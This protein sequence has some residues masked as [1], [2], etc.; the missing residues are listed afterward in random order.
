MGSLYKDDLLKFQK[1][2]NESAELLGI[3]VDY[4]Y[5][6]KRKTKESKVKQEEI[7]VW[8][9]NS[10]KKY[11]RK[12]CIIFTRHYFRKYGKSTS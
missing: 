7:V 4:R 6:I 1:Y 5:I 10:F 12:K 2:F 3:T 9:D 8:K 11:I